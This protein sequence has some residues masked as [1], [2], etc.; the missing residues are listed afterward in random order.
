M[1]VPEKKDIANKIRAARIKNQ[2]SAADLFEE[3]KNGN[4]AA[5]GQAITLLESTKPEHEL[6]A[7]ELVDKCLTVSGQSI[8]IGISG[9]PGVGKSTFIESFGSLLTSQGKKLAVLAVDPSS[10]KSG[11]SILGDK[12]R[13]ETLAQNANAF[14]RPTPAGGSLGGVALKTREAIILCE[15][16]GYDVILIETVGVGQSETAV[17]SMVDFFLL[18]M[19]SGAGDEL[20][21]IK[22]GIMEMADAL[23]ITKA[24]GDNIHPAKLASRTY[25]NALHLFPASESGWIPQVLSCSAQEQTGLTEIWELIE[26]FENQ[27]KINGHFEEERKRQAVHWMHEA[28]MEELR[29]SFY[30]SNQAAEIAQLEEQVQNQ[31]ISPKNAAKLAMAKRSGNKYGP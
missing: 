29:S 28:I 22:R 5:L 27:L 1:R 10:K 7:S 14:I 12:T 2:Q 4:I 15:A 25:K 24:D 20:Q 6:I 8:R 13:M 11:G 3:I 19:L 16:A 23:V 31:T 26:S 21:G 18:L 17:K 9:V 30:N